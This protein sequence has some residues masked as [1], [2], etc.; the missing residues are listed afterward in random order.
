MPQESRDGGKVIYSQEHR[1]LIGLLREARE[2]AGLTQAQLSARLGRNIDYVV[3]VEGGFRRVDTIEWLWL[4][5]ALGADP[6]EFLLRLAP[7]FAPPLRLKMT[8]PETTPTLAATAAWTAVQD[9]AE[10]E[11]SAESGAP[12]A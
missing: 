3:R 11:Q 4:L 12:L 7:A 8:S 10:G 9:R 6:G 2:A 5:R 1:A